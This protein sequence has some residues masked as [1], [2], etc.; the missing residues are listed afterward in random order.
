M[1]GLNIESILSFPCNI[2]QTG[3][4]A[5]GADFLGITVVKTDNDLCQTTHLNFDYNFFKCMHT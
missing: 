1:V 3:E 5:V 4:G 2:F